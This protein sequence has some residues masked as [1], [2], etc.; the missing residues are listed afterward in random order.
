ML[1]LIKVLGN[2]RFPSAVTQLAQSLTR[3]GCGPCEVLTV[4]EC[5]YDESANI[6]SPSF[7]THGALILMQELT[8]CSAS[9]R[10]FG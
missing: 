2:V 9:P 8:A 1:S 7:H 4:I 6:C 3:D 5:D 10:E